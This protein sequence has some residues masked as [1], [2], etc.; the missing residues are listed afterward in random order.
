MALSMP[1]GAADKG[2]WE[3]RVTPL[4]WAPSLYADA[5]IGRNPPTS[6]ETS[7][8]DVLDLAFMSTFEARK[9]R[10]GVIG[11]FNFLALSQ[12]SSFAGGFLG[13]K[14]KVSGFMLG[15]AGAYRFYED[16]V[17]N[18][19]V[20]AGA[21][22]WSLDTEIKF[23]RIGTVER[24]ANLVDPIIGIRGQYAITENW[25]VGGLAEIGGF[26]VGSDFQWE[27][28]GRAGYRLNDN[29]AIAAGWR[30]LNI[31]LDD[32]GLILDATLT[33]PFVAVDVTF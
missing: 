17:A 8:L 33:G 12:K 6:T 1:A 30:H 22:F 29:F 5:N 16:P 9:G 32:N 25:F 2:S 27:V 7:L 23:R 15:A 21:R 24:S 10:W 4:V 20:F 14:T 13:A 28:I 19:D 11:E 26:G 18:A 3:F 31:D